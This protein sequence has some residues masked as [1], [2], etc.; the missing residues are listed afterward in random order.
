MT[1]QQMSELAVAAVFAGVLAALGIGATIAGNWLKTDAAKREL[2]VRKQAL[3]ASVRLV[4]ANDESQQVAA[5]LQRYKRYMEKQFREAWPL[6]GTPLKFW[7]IEKH[8]DRHKPVIK[9]REK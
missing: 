7:Y 6:S 9:P 3:D 2:Q 1:R 8:V 4:R 5:Y